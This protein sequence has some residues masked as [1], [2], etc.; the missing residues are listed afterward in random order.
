[1]PMRGLAGSIASL[2]EPVTALAVNRS[3]ELAGDRRF[4]S[5]EGAPGGGLDDV[6]GV[7]L[8]FLATREF[9][10]HLVLLLGCRGL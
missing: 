10:G 5:A 3:R 4:A 9:L 2:R 7:E 1:M 8:G 6:V